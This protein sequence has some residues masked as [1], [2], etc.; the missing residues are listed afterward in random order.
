MLVR[1]RNG[2][3]RRG[4][5]PKHLLGYIFIINREVGKGE[6]THIFP[7]FKSSIINFFYMSGGGV[8]DPIWPNG[9]CHDTMEMNKRQ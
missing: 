5:H 1:E 9:V 6:K 2:Q 7:F 4:R 3:A 8:L